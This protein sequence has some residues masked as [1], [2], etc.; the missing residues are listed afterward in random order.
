[1][2]K[3]LPLIFLSSSAFAEEQLPEYPKCAS[4]KDVV[5]V[6]TTKYG[7]DIRW[8]GIS[9]DGRYALLENKDTKS[10]TLIKYD[11]TTACVQGAGIGSQIQLP[12]IKVS[13]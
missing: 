4:F 10:W 7:E 13:L 2:K 1:M 11:S 3:L 9:T 5:S 8:S 12:G 6:L